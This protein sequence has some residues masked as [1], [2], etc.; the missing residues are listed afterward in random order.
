VF[1]D[2]LCAGFNRRPFKIAVPLSADGAEYSEQVI[3]LN[4]SECTIRTIFKKSRLREEA[5]TAASSGKKPRRDNPSEPKKYF[6]NNIIKYK[7]SHGVRIGEIVEV[8]IDGSP[9]D[10]VR[11]KD[12]FYSG[13]GPDTVYV[14]DIVELVAANFHEWEQQQDQA[15]ADTSSGAASA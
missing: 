5:T 12:P 10:F 4:L 14:N 7:A 8:T 6:N 15:N 1:Y 11:A 13:A 9:N 3:S 2:L